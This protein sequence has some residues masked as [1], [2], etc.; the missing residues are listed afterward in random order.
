[1]SFTKNLKH[2]DMFRSATDDHQGVYVFLVK[3]TELKCEHSYVVMWLCC[4]ITYFAYMW[5][6]VW[7]GVQTLQTLYLRCLAQNRHQFGGGRGAR[8]KDGESFYKIPANL[9]LIG[10]ILFFSRGNLLRAV[11]HSRGQQIHECILFFRLGLHCAYSASSCLL[12]NYE[13]RNWQPGDSAAQDH[14]PATHGQEPNTL[15]MRQSSPVFLQGLRCEIPLGPQS[16][17]AHK[18]LVHIRVTGCIIQ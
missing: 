18:F 12:Y 16:V 15:L 2:S 10:N 14:G 5:C 6:L 4:S 8:E 3:I 9:L 13:Y 7:W 11:K 1:M 17:P